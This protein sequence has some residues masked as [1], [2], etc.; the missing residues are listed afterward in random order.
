[1]TGVRALDACAVPSF[2]SSPVSAL[3]PLSTLLRHSTFQSVV[4][5]QPFSNRYRITIRLSRY[6]R[7]LHQVSNTINMKSYAIILSGLAAMACAQDDSSSSVDA[8]LASVSA[9]VASISAQVESA[10]A[11]ATSNASLSPDQLASYNS[12]QYSIAT[13]AMVRRSMA[14]RPN[15]AT[16]SLAD[17]HSRARSLASSLLH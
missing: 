14:H 12:A 8:I 4:T 7:S 9:Q 3:F 10:A 16:S 17:D 6:Q 13:A 5:T 15:C 1:M 2:I 11:A